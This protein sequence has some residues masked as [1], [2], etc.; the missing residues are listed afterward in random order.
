MA[1]YSKAAMLIKTTYSTHEIK[2][3]NGYT[4]ANSEEEAIGAY[5]KYLQTEFPGYAVKDVL[6]LEIPQA[7]IDKL[8]TKPEVT[9]E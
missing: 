9:D 7:D 3:T 4:T 6:V 1:L 8:A 2:L 5:Y